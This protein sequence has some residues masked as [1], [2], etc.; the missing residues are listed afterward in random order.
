MRAD[1][2]EVKAI[3]WLGSFESEKR[4]AFCYD[5]AAAYLAFNAA[6]SND[7]ASSSLLAPRNFHAPAM[8]TELLSN[9][10]EDPDVVLLAMDLITALAVSVANKV[11]CDELRPIHV[12][13]DSR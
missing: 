10:S 8:L 2:K 13:A 4:A 9:A 1:D 5:V 12:Q 7:T 3:L 11:P 6:R